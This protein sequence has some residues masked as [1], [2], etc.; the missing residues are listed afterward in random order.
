MQVR[1]VEE[2][3][4]GGAHVREVDSAHLFRGNK[5]ILFGVPAAFSPSC[6]DKHLPSY[7]TTLHELK[8]AGIDSI[9][10]L[11]VNDAFVM[12]A[13]AKQTGAL[14]KI[15]F[16]ADGNG[17]FSKKLGL[18]TDATA[19]GMG[20]RSRRFALVISNGEVVHVA[21]DKPM[22]TDVSTAQ[23]VLPRLSKL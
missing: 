12:K 22:T 21:V 20:Q 6:S 13:W 19:G 15:S 5:V 17:D 1:L 18:L 10:C 14:G 2:A 23:S 8:A 16:I 4:D 3:S 9:Y 11:A 7:L